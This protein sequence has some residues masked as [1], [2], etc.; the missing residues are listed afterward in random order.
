MRR[1]TRGFLLSLALG[2]VCA[3]ADPGAPVFEK[4]ILPIFTEYCFTCHGQSSPK[5]GLDLRSAGTTLRGSHN[6]PVIVKGSPE[7]SV[8]FQKVSAHVMPPAIYGQKV[9]D[10]HIETL[11]RWIAAGAPSDQAAGVDG[12]E[13]SEQHARFEKEIL[14]LFNARCVQCHGAGKPM[15]G[16]DLRTAAA[17]LKGS[18]SGPVIVEGFS[19]RSLLIRKIA[20]HSMP[21][22]GAGQPLSEAEIRTLREWIDRGHFTDGFDANSADRPFTK[23]EAPEITAEQRRFWSFR[24]PSAAPVPKPRSASR[25]RTPIDAFLLAK[26]ESQGFGYSADAASA[27][28]M[29]RAYFDL[30]GLPPTPDEVRAVP[31]RRPS[32]RL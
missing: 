32:R 20:S 25:V 15:A 14:P 11:K 13:A 3:H 19:E 21:P 27:T 26:L 6:G 31:V 28:L 23:L 7:Q 17:V 30:T 22:P 1:L 2:G 18:Q 10:A 5:L 16:L 29:R 8:L 9:P 12:K 4:D 24:K